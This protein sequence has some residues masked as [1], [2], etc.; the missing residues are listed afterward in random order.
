MVEGERW[1]RTLAMQ[2]IVDENTLPDKKY[3][4]D[5]ITMDSY[6]WTVAMYLA[7]I[8]IVPPK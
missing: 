6:G 7:N 4:H 3:Y 1:D 8:G 5:K 2:Q